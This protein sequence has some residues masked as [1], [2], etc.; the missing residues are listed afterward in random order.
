MKLIFAT[1]NQ[2]KII[3]VQSLLPKSIK[4]LSL[5]DINYT[6][7]IEET[8]ITLEENAQI[9][10]DAIYSSTLLNCFAEDSGLFVHQ[11]NGEP[12][13]HS[14]R[15]AAINSTS[16]ENTSKLLIQLKNTTNRE[17]YFKTVFSLCING[18][19]TLFSGI[20]EGTITKESQG[21]GGFG[22]DSV[23]IPRGYTSTFAHMTRAQKQAISHRSLAL[24]KM[25][26][27]LGLL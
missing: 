25:I 6:N 5:L 14:A 1:S 12:G 4:L 21:N 27:Y 20:I 10:S 11:L 8:G 23:F 13:V 24:H 17:A 9:K 3:E 19:S 26:H 7:E 15:Y 18:A 22:Y 2:N 16:Q